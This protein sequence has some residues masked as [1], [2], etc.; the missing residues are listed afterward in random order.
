MASLT[1]VSKADTSSRACHDHRSNRTHRAN[2]CHKSFFY[3][4][5]FV[6]H[7]DTDIARALFCKK[8]KLVTKG[9]H[10]VHMNVSFTTH[11][12]LDN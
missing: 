1:P 8:K 10:P 6:D 3:F 9:L 5:T 12:G 11:L 4:I 2:Y 7:L